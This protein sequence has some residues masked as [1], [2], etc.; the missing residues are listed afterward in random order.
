M[1]KKKTVFAGVDAGTLLYSSMG[2]PDQSMD[3][4]AKGLADFQKSE[5]EADEHNMQKEAE[6]EYHRLKAEE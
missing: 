3:M 1:K 6:V 5:A 2:Q 4:M